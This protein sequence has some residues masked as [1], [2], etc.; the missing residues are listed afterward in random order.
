MS[1]SGGRIRPNSSYLSHI[2]I[3]G[4]SSTRQIQVEAASISGYMTSSLEHVPPTTATVSECILFRHASFFFLWKPIGNALQM[5]LLHL[6]ALFCICA[7]GR[8]YEISVRNLGDT[9]YL[10]TNAELG[11]FGGSNLDVLNVFP[12]DVLKF[13]VNAPGH[14]FAIHSSAGITSS[15]NRYN[16]GVTNQGTETSTLTFTIPESAP[17]VLHYQCEIHSAQTGQIRIGLAPLASQPGVV[18]F[19]QTT[20]AVPPF[21]APC[22]SA[23]YR[24]SSSL[25]VARNSINITTS[26]T[27]GLCG[28]SPTGWLAF[29]DVAYV[30]GDCY[31]GTMSR[32][33]QEYGTYLTGPARFGWNPTTMR[34]RTSIWGNGPNAN[35]DFAVQD[36]LGC[37]GSN[38]TFNQPLA[39]CFAAS[40]CPAAC[41]PCNVES[42]PTTTAPAG[43]GSGAQLSFSAVLIMIMLGIVCF[44]S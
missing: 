34:F 15:A 27:S 20:T 30:S 44:L 43:T 18:S 7:H 25:T 38:N 26:G 14:P 21:S 42:T 17:N 24:A 9:A 23:I 35:C 31:V 4:H 40:G 22:C 33:S 10:L 37:A 39:G 16:V 5:G 2:L 1:A 19:R 13:N 28:A 29:T 6:V 8:T 36:T 11:L 41:G 32:F 12:G 3:G